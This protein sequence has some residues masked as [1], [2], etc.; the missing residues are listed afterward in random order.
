MNCM[1]CWSFFEMFVTLNLKFV[2]W[3]LIYMDQ[4]LYRGILPVNPCDVCSFPED[5]FECFFFGRIIFY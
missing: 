4:S 3:T 1:H 5:S 2:F